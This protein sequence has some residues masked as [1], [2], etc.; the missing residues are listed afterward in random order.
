[1]RQFTLIIIFALSVCLSVINGQ[2]AGHDVSSVLEKLYARLGKSTEDADRLRIND[3]IKIIIGDYVRSDSIFQHKFT[4]LRYLGQITSPDLQLKIVT[5]NLIL[6]NSAGRYFCYFILRSGKENKVYDLTTTY[7]ADPIRTDTTYSG[8]NWY[9][10]LY[11]DLRELKKEN[12]GTWML[13]GIDYGHPSITRKIIDVLTFAPGGEILFGKKWFA[14][15]DVVKYRE[16]LEYTS[17][18]VISMRFVSDR[19]I[20]F[21]H[22]VPTSKEL[23]GNREFYAPDY[24]YDAYNFNK[25]IWRLEMNVDIKNTKNPLPRKGGSLK[26]LKEKAD[27]K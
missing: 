9:G 6:K 26:T 27:D 18:A 24:S 3:S 22:L 11:Y 2:T 1:M 25:G 17:T 13:L 8:K 12:R 15:G 23:A 4:S 10:A 14:T 20:V 19:S 5:W 16:V 21:D 7:K